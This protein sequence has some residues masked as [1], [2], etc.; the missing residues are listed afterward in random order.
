MNHSAGGRRHTRI[1]W[2]PREIDLL[3]RARRDGD[4]G[5]MEELVRRMMPLARR[6]ARRYSR[7]VEPL[8]DLEQVASFGLLGALRRFDPHRGTDFCAYAVASIDGELKHYHR[9]RCWSTRV[10]AP[11]RSGPSS[12]TASANVFRRRWGGVRPRTNFWPGAEERGINCSTQA[13]RT[14]RARA[15]RLRPTKLSLSPTSRKRDTSASRMR[16]SSHIF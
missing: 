10:R 7:S 4:A 2:G 14:R 15:Y 13:G 8:D 16:T 1:V 11:P 9:G 5:A 12:S 6:V 3:T